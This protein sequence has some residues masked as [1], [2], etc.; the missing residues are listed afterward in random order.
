MVILDVIEDTSDNA[1]AEPKGQDG[2]VLTFGDI[3]AFVYAA[4]I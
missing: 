2:S 4:S 3:V 1:Q